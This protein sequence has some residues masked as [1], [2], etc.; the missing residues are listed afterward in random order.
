MEPATRKDRG[1]VTWFEDLRRKFGLEFE[2]EHWGHTKLLSLFL[3][4]PALCLY[5]YPELIRDGAGRK[6]T[7]QDTYNRYS[8]NVRTLYRNIEFVGMS[9]YKPEAA[10]GIPMEH[11]YIPLT[12]R[13]EAADETSNIPGINPLSL[14]VPGTQCAILGDPGSGKSIL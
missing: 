12:V 1:D 7:I 6:K 8:D 11:I 13:P 14:L 4:T 10:K 9:V 5:Y 2:I 3:E